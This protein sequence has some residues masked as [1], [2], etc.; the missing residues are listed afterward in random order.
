MELII[1]VFSVVLASGISLGVGASTLAVLNFFHAIKDGKIDMTERSFM[2]VTYTV[3]RVAMG[4]VL[5]SALLLTVIGLNTYGEVYFTGY[6]AAQALL[7]AILFLNS[8]LMT[9]RVMPST[10][11]P[12]IQASSWYSLGVLSALLPFGITHFNFFLFLFIYGTFL[13]FA[14]SLINSI[15]AY[16]K[17]KLETQPQPPASS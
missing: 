12:A 15:M 6:V 8:F 4:I 11:G 3:L 14:I 16:L 9:I 1:L 13:F 17:E 7:I 5:V 10:F 2:G